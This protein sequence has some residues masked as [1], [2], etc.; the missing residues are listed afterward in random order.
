MTALPAPYP[1]LL[2]IALVAIVIYS[3]VHLVRLE[4]AEAAAR[5]AN[6]RRAL[7]N[8]GVAR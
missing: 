8:K 6:R 5:A 3:A 2:T 7:G 1:T 4:K